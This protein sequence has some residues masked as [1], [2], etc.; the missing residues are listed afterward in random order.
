MFDSLLSESLFVVAAMFFMSL[1]G[2][3]ILFAVLKSVAQINNKAYQAGGA[4]AGFIIL[5][6]TLF[7][8]Y[9][10]LHHI[11][12]TENNLKAAQKH[13]EKNEING[14][15]I[16]T[17]QTAK[18]VLAT[19]QTDADDNGKF[20]LLAKCINPVDDDVKVYVIS[21]DGRYRSLRISSMDKMKNLEI[22][23]Q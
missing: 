8:S 17:S 14:T 6:A 23:T 22:K 15:I 4:L 3:Y 16:P 12:E 1:I 11:E 5:Y 10:S 19:Q 13:L 2:A 18:I 7:Q 20:K 9:Q 21:Q